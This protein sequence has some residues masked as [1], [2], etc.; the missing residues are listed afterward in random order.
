MAKRKARVIFSFPEP[1]TRPIGHVNWADPSF[2]MTAD[3]H[4]FNPEE[5]HSPAAHGE[6][7]GVRSGPQYN[8][9]AAQ[10]WHE[11]EQW[12]AM[13]KRKGFGREEKE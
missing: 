8:S 7:R 12:G 11:H 10:T 3:V 2:G 5:Y 1:D 9:P 4:T 6:S 13:N